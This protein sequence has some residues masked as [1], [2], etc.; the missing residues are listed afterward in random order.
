MRNGNFLKMRISEIRVKRIR[1]NQ[2]LGVYLFIKC[3]EELLTGGNSTLMK[4][5]SSD[6]SRIEMDIS[7]YLN[8][9]LNGHC[10]SLEAT[11]TTSSLIKAPISFAFKSM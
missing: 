1:V 3:T 6:R 9:K 2:G 5:S 10:L 7:A 8:N 4:F 11:T